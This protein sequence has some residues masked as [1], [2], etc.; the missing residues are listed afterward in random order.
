MLRGK[1]ATAR[2]AALKREQHGHFQLPHHFIESLLLLADGHAVA[3]RLRAV[4]AERVRGRLAH[5]HRPVTSRGTE[6]REDSHAGRRMIMVFDH[7]DSTAF[8]GWRLSM[9]D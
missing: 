6:H 8:G 2:R 9:S 4:A 3:P 1:Q 7:M 5:L